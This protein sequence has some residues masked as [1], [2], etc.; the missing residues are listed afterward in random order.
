MLIEVGTDSLIKDDLIAFHAKQFPTQPRPE[1]V[2]VES[3]A[4]LNFDTYLQEDD[5][6]G[7]YSDGVERTL[8]DKQIAVFRHRELTEIIQ[9][10][11]AEQ[12]EQHQQHQ[13]HHEVN[14]DTTEDTL[15]SSVH[16]DT[17][18]SSQLPAEPPFPDTP[19]PQPH[20]VSTGSATDQE[21]LT[22]TLAHADAVLPPVNEVTGRQPLL[23]DITQ[24][25]SQSRRDSSA[26]P[27]TNGPTKR[28]KRKQE[29][30]YDQRHKRKWEQYIDGNDPRHGSMTHRRLVRELDEQKVE[31]IEMDY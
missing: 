10:H 27:S 16:E 14:A 6:L 22:S 21:T 31:S 5:G 24:Q 12:A 20:P 26:T 25:P 7:Y 18:E 9:R 28:R 8:T 1:K 4:A 17:M 30:P 2:F 11:Q 15:N 19:Q 23:P 13:P 3:E 29:T